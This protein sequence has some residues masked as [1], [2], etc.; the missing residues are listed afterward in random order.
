MRIPKTSENLKDTENLKKHTSISC[1]KG[2]EHSDTYIIQYLKN[3]IPQEEKGWYVD[4][5][6]KFIKDFEGMEAWSPHIAWKLRAIYELVLAKE[7]GEMKPPGG[8][9]K[10]LHKIAGGIDKRFIEEG[11]RYEGFPEVHLEGDV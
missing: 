2:H 9:L 5:C 11:R 3:E 7:R 8:W 1:G 6:R 4:T 10:T